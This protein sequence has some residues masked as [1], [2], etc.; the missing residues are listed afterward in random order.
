MLEAF[1]L[2]VICTISLLLV[3]SMLIFGPRILELID[4]E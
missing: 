3:G 4:G 1:L 2:G